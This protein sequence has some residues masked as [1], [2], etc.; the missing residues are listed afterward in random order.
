MNAGDFLPDARKKLED[1]R[2]LTLLTLLVK[3]EAENQSIEGM[4]AV[5][6]V[7]M[8]RYRKGGW[9]GNTIPK[10]ILKKKQFSCFN[11]DN[12]NKRRIMA[13]KA[14]KW[15]TFCFNAAYLAYC[16]AVKDPTNGADHYH[17]RSVKPRWAS[18]MTKTVEIGN[19]IFYRSKP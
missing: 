11:E 16:N 18:K 13:A 2:D 8:N 19:H 1:Q 17:A 5:G 9:F 4:I 10:V 14:D 3:G 15:W 7:A 12:V 6:F